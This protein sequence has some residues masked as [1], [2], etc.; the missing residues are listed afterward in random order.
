[1]WP[2][3]F[4]V[5]SVLCF[6]SSSVA[7]TDYIELCVHLKSGIIEVV[8]EEGTCRNNYYRISVMTRNDN[9]YQSQIDGLRS[10]V[11]LLQQ[12]VQTIQTDVDDI[13]GR[14]AEPQILIPSEFPVAEGSSEW[15]GRPMTVALSKP[16]VYTV[17]VDYVGV[18]GTVPLTDIAGS[19]E[20][21]YWPWYYWE[22]EP[23]AGQ[24]VF[25]PGETEKTINI[26]TRGNL[27]I[28]NIDRHFFVQFSNPSYSTLP[29]DTALVRIDDDDKPVVYVGGRAYPSGWE[30]STFSFRLHVLDRFLEPGY[31]CQP[32]YRSHYAYANHDGITVTFSDIVEWRTIDP[33][34]DDLL[35]VGDDFLFDAEPVHI[36][37]GE[38]Y[39]DMTIPTVDDDVPENQ[40]SVLI[41]AAVSDN[42][43]IGCQDAL[44]LRLNDND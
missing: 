17:T 28:E 35:T 16:H 44:R 14:L 10:Q 3:I 5:L 26:F 36:P 25:A 30:G 1:M 37:P 38:S 42:A 8:D 43:S 6:A 13:L 31:D 19:A 29:L 2:R 22:T 12:Q 41:P 21:V 4:F 33:Y 40:E 9:D 34:Y 27:I 11:L 39:I 24:L 18:A 15:S 7:G 32:E 23:L 20:I